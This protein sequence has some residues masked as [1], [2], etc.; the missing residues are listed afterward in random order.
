LATV[1][2]F[3]H[4]YFAGHFVFLSL[5]Q[6]YQTTIGV[7]FALK[8]V[9]M[10][11][12]ELNVQLWDIAGQERFAGLSRIFYTHAVAAII[13]YDVT[14]RD[15]FDSVLK[16]KQDI[17]AK[18]FLPSGAKIPVLLL[19]NKSD[20]LTGEQAQPPCVS[21]DEL[22]AFVAQH[23]FFASA[24][25]SAATGHNVKESC[26]NLVTKI[27]QNNQTEMTTPADK[28]QGQNIRQQCGQNW[29]HCM[30]SFGIFRLQSLMC[31]FCLFLVLLQPRSPPASPLPCRRR[32]RRRADAAVKRAPK[33]GTKRIFV[34]FL[35]FRPLPSLL[36]SLL[37]LCSSRL[38]S[39]SFCCISFL[40]FFDV[41]LPPSPPCA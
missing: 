18:V 13:V 40:L 14:S 19:G 28:Q 26:I 31:C 15:T 4:V 2:F 12:S 17:D 39:S 32:S 20:L 27:H 38:S 25:C 9:R 29:F 34:C 8:R 23:D 22:R 5:L 41:W 21:A 36:S 33:F 7:D 10:G 6:D 37:A 30:Q 3:S 16:W 35:S 1:V 11:T 24:E